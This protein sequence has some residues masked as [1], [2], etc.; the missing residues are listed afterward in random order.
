M[1]YRCKVFVCG[2]TAFLL[3]FSCSCTTNNGNEIEKDDQAYAYLEVFIEMVGSIEEDRIEYIGIDTAKI[4]HRNP[5]AIRKLL[6]DYAKEYDVA[7]R[8]NTKKDQCD[9]RFFQKGWLIIF[10]DIELT[11]I[12]LVTEATW[13]GAV[14]LASANATY[15]VEREDE[16]GSWRVI[17]NQLNWIS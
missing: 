11:E 16:E 1:S 6:E 5:S 10:E 15:I 13:M 3:V 17:D 4:L 14:A 8:W 2:I 7:I 9:Y 12:K